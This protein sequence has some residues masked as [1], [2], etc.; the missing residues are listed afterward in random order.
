MC[1]IQRPHMFWF[2]ILVTLRVSGHVECN[3]PHKKHRTKS[4]VGRENGV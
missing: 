2:D 4:G 1:Y 3:V